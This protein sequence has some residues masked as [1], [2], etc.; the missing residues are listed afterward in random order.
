MKMCT[1]FQ[2]K[3]TDGKLSKPKTL[4]WT[5]INRQYYVY[6]WKKIELKI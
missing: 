4:R 2:A 1:K 6:I 3:V 5:V